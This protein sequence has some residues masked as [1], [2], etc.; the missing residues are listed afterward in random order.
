[1]PL[2]PV[3]LN[4][5]DNSYVSMPANS[6]AERDFVVVR[7]HGSVLLFPAI[8]LGLLCAGFFFVDPK[9]TEVWQH[10]ALLVAVVVLAV[11]FWLLPSI[12]F[13]T[14]RYEITSNR[15]IVHRGLTGG[16]VDQ[17]AWGELSGVSVTRGFGM[18]LRGAGNIH[19]HR[20]FGVDLIL[21]K[22]PRAKK[23][24]REF[25]NY[26]ASRQRVGE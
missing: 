21:H 16:K 19:L 3:T 24:A 2:L 12:R 17:A 10:Q 11:L 20:E 8:F 22:A 1:M 7:R 25:E 5:C 4:T 6:F 9:L 15:V 18:W 26:M 14:N 23:L 13:H